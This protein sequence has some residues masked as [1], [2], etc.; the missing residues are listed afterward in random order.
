MKHPHKIL[1]TT[2]QKRT[3]YLAFGSL[4][5]SGVVWLLAVEG[6]PVRNLSMKIHGAAAMAFLMVFGSLLLQHVPHGWA[7]NRQRPSGGWVSALCGV[8]TVTGWM[9]Y[10]I[11]NES[12][13]HATSLIHW[14]I[15]LLIPAL[16]ILHVILGR[17]Q[18]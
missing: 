12:V 3:L 8:L 9:L 11:A 6:S 4:W 18:D 13:R 10:Y 7:Q 5:V 1:L 2:G 15:G 17:R 16:L 14:T